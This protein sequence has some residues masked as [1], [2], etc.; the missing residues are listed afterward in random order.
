MALDSVINLGGLGG[1]AGTIWFV[2]QVVIA[3]AIVSFMFWKFILYPKS[4]KDI[5]EI[6]DVTDAGTIRWHDRGKWVIDKSDGTG[7]YKLLKHKNAKLK[8]PPLS[9]AIPTK[10]GKYKYLFVRTGESGYDYA[11]LNQNDWVKDKAPIP[12]NLSDTDW[13]KLNLKQSLAKRSLSGFWN[14]NKGAIIFITA[15]VL[16]LVLLNWVI[17]F[18]S[19]SVQAITNTAGQQASALTEIAESLQGIANQLN[20]SG[21]SQGI[22]PP[23]GF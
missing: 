3:G 11:C 16:T 2:C 18:A 5:V 6:F 4:F 8:Q 21:V 23:A 1:M 12:M 17:A 9:H 15:C 20:P 14:Q 7:V 19:D 10:K 22:E 13:V